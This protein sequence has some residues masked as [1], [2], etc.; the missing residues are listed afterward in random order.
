MKV[1]LK[2]KRLDLS[3]FCALLIVALGVSPALAQ[4]GQGGNI[5]GM[6]R[7]MGQG[8]SP[9][10]GPGMGQGMMN[11]YGFDRYDSRFAGFGSITFEEVCNNFGV[12]VETALSDLNLPEDMDTNL[13]VLEVEEQ[14]GVSG[15]EIASY[16]VTNMQQ[17]PTSLNAR[18]RLLMRQQAIQNMRGMGQGMYFM[19]HGR[20]AYGNYTTFSLMPI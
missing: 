4:M 6:G 13:T 17:T 16:M 8:M 9:G 3:V 2:M 12:P 19:H 20:F 5:D 18:Q 15:Q 10:M 14:Y 11:G 1:K 7:G